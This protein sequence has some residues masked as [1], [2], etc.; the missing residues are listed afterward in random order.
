MNYFIDAHKILT[1]ATVIFKGAGVKQTNLFSYPNPLK[2][3]AGYGWKLVNGEP[4]Q[5]I[6]KRGILYSKTTGEAFNWQELGE[7]P[8][9]YTPLKPNAGQLWTGSAW[10]DT[11]EIKLANAYN[12]KLSDHN[13]Q[14]SD[15]SASFYSNVTGI[16]YRYSTDNEAQ[17]NL[18]GLVLANIDCDYICYKDN[19][20]LT[21]NHSA[22]QL[23]E[24]GL[25]ITAYKA[26]LIGTHAALLQQLETF[27]A[28]EN[29]A[30][31]EALSWPSS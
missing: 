25:Q 19:E 22:S 11:Q 16:T 9:T 4:V 30:A 24:L 13:Q 18:T 21:I 29:L 5:L 23:R 10:D 12:Q 14:L 26:T 28:A 31:I 1:P 3:K 27:K 7:Y 8:D 6:D 17:L 2:V 15:K 20:R